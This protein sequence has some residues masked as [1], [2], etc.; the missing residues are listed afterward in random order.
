MAATHEAAA[1]TRRSERPEA[2]YAKLR[3]GPGKPAREVA[4]HQRARIHS[5]MIEIV[6][7]RGLAA[8]TIREITR[9]A[10]VSSRA[11]YK[12]FDGTQECF[13]A[14]YDLV[15]RR[16]AIRV[17]ASQAGEHDWEKRLRLAFDAFVREVQG[18][19]HAAHLA[20]IDAYAGGPEALERIRHTENMFEAMLAESFARAPGEA[21]MPPLM[22]RGLAAGTARVARLSLLADAEASAPEVANQLSEWALSFQDASASL[23]ARLDCGS[24]ARD[25]LISTSEKMMRPRIS[26]DARNLILAATLKLAVAGGYDN[27]TVP[28]IRAAA[29]VPPRTFAAHFSGVDECFFAALEFRANE[30]FRRANTAGSK[31]LTWE[32]KVYR[33]LAALCTYFTGDQTLARLC[34]ID[35]FAPGK[36]GMHFRDRF[37]S[38]TVDLLHGSEQAANPLDRISI[39]ASA[40]AIWGVMHHQVTSGQLRRHS[41]VTGTLS[42]LVLAPPL[43]PTAALDAIDVEQN[44]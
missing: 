20:L 1:P 27:L 6:A 26:S 28:R 23:L 15:V 4:A 2:L 7:D 14:T 19:P 8:V 21:E 17:V 13:L 16:A 44:R 33:S 22:I 24:T 11:F 10:G 32:A 41:R 3:P 31:G 43:G 29:G 12:H 34:F 30:A 42:L 25:P 40:G 38:S 36:D 39:E 37:I 9:L 5:A 35:G 18:A